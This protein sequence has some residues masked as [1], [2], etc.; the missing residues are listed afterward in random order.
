MSDLEKIEVVLNEI[1][2]AY[3]LTDSVKNILKDNIIKRAS[4]YNGITPNING[5]EA[6]IIINPSSII[7]IFLNRLVNNIREYKIGNT[8]IPSS[9]LTNKGDYA[10]LKQTLTVENFNAIRESIK[11]KFDSR[12]IQ[13]SNERLNI[14][15]RK[16]FNHEIGHALQ[17]SFKGNDGLFNNNYNMVVSSLARK[18]PNIFKMPDKLA[19]KKIHGGVKA[20]DNSNYSRFLEGNKLLDEIFNESEA[21]EISNMKDAQV[22]Y[23]MKFGN[24]KIYNYDSSNY[25]ITSYGIMMKIIM[26]KTKTYRAMYEDSAVIYDFFDQFK[27]TSK[28]VFKTND[29]TMPMQAILNGLDKIRNDSNMD[30]ANDL[31]LFFTKCLEKRVHHDLRNPNM[32]VQEIDRITDYIETFENQM[33]KSPNNNLQQEVIINSLKELVKKQNNEIN[34]ENSIEENIIDNTQNTINIGNS[35]QK[36]N[37]DDYKYCLEQIENIINLRRR[38]K[39]Y[40]DEEKRKLTGKI[41]YYEGYMINGLKNEKDIEVVLEEVVSK[42][43]GDAFEKKIQSD[44]LR[45][46]QEKYQKDFSVKSKLEEKT[47]LEQFL[48]ELRREVNDIQQKYRK[49]FFTEYD[50]DEQDVLIRRISNIGSSLYSLRDLTSNNKE[51]EIIS[52][53]E[54]LINGE[55]IKMNTIKNQAEAAVKILG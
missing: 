55:L 36:E 13:I 44:I 40:S 31:D 32:S 27:D 41:F 51:L 14:C 23:N 16:V 24:K 10:D 1:Q 38:K 8:Y 43:D 3:G 12:G 39:D 34:R 49:M 37:L 6:S 53:L 25:K 2:N 54:E 15:V 20:N 30:V 45:D 21:M 52:S 26:G 11:D 9:Q 17:H 47:Q 48:G 46:L 28:E 5:E 33:I 4:M 22:S 19:I 50:S 18:Y 29:T 35:E 42:F 7:D